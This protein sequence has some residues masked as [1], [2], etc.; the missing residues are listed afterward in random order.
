MSKLDDI[1]MKV[2]KNMPGRG[3]AALDPAMIPVIIDIVGNLVTL[4]K[5]CNKTSGE[6]VKSAK[7][8]SLWEKVALK[9]TVR[10]QLG[11]GFFKFRREGDDLVEAV[12]KTGKGMTENDMNELY[13]EV[14]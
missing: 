13:D 5:Q 1:S 6:A 11:M 3:E 10:K 14:E 8:P 2:A 7:N 4:F 12:M 9:Q